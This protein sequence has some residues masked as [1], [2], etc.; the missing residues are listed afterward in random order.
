MYIRTLYTQSYIVI[1]IHHRRASTII[2]TVVIFYINFEYIGNDEWYNQTTMTVTKCP[3]IYKNLFEHNFSVYTR[4][5]CMN[6]RTVDCGMFKFNHYIA[7]FEGF[8][9]NASLILN[10]WFFFTLSTDHPPKKKRIIPLDW[11]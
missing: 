3:R 1:I 11:F 2:Y 7:K 8:S 10:F 5:M 9:S 6:A 4:S